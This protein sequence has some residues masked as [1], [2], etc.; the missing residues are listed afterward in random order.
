M[1]IL[2]LED[3]ANDA[4]LVEDKILQEWPRA[5]INRVGTRDEF[6][7]ALERGGFDLI[8]SDYTLVDFNGLEAL[9]IARSICPEKPYVFISGTIG[10]ERAIEALK[11][12][13]T[14][15][16]IKDHPGRLVPAIKQALS[17]AEEVN[18]RRRSE[19]RFHDLFEFAPD[20]I[21][22]TDS[23]GMITLVNQKVEKL[24][25]YERAALVGKSIDKLMSASAKLGPGAFLRQFLADTKQGAIGKGVSIFRATKKDGTEF[26][27]E[28]SRGPMEF[29]TGT[30]V[31]A[32]IRD[33]TE[34]E[35]AQRIMLRTQRMESIGTLAGGIAHDLNNALAPIVMGVG[36]LRMQY[37]G[38]TAMIDTMEASAQRGADMVRQ[39]MTFAKGLEGERLNLQPGQLINE[40]RKIIESTFPKNINLRIALPN[41]LKTVLGDATQ[42]HQVLLNLCVNA[43]D[44]MPNGGILTLEA[45]NVEVDATFA[46][47]IEDAKVGTYVRWRVIDTGTGMSPD[48]IERIFEPFYTTK[49]PNLGTGLGLS[50]LL[51]IV[52]SHEGFIR[53]HSEIGR[54]ST[55]SVYLPASSRG[56][57]DSPAPVKLQTTIQGNGE[58]ILMVDDEAPVRQVARS[59]LTSL[60]FKVITAADGAEALSLVAQNKALLRL[61]ITDSQM[62]HMDG[63]NF[64]R[65]LKYMIPE[66]P[67]IVTSGGLNEKEAGEFRALEVSALL[68]KPFTQDKLV[69]A[70]SVAL[71]GSPPSGTRWSGG[72][73]SASR[74]A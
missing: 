44:A 9:E 7:V 15:Y 70:L 55:F 37:P 8:L 60:D 50:T 5:L 25:G 49:G 29:E 27:V 57:G 31:V 21:V 17:L 6:R 12:G 22:M 10:E 3:S 19:K 40:M 73:T 24:F 18:R 51:G 33:V 11:R 69:E 16:I 58:T 46:S 53:V 56:A 35:N 74:D 64:V 48:V 34:R 30:G 68:E 26:P 20:A 4:E 52:K 59:V 1:N 2:H 63:M 42:L 41:N 61:V 45:G 23:E 54:G 32:A 67:I 39:L 13:A 28:L 43:R 66:T 36:M 47:S 72:A 71:K 62:P 65:I 14:D 38:A